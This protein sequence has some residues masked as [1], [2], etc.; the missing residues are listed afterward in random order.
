MVMIAGGLT[1]LGC[2]R[3]ANGLQILIHPDPRLRMVAE[4]VEVIDREVVAL[5][6][7]MKSLL[8]SKSQRDFFTAGSMHPG[9]AAPQVGFSK[10]IIVCG[11][12]GELKTL[13]NPVITSRRGVHTTEEKCLSLPSAPAIRVRRSERININYRD[14]ENEQI[15][16]DLRYRYAA[17][18]E[19]EIDHLNGKLYIDY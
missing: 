16:L 15:N 11:I 3:P 5:V 1:P 18:V 8:I 17:L 12:N 14:L 10:R 2:D 6:E 19:H 9:L 7:A 4:P 13:V